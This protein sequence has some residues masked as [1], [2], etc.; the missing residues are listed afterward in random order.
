MPRSYVCSRVHELRGFLE[1]CKWGAPCLAR[2]GGQTQE[3]LPA[4][5]LDV[6]LGRFVRDGRVG[7]GEWEL[8]T[9]ADPTAQASAA[10]VRVGFLY[11]TNVLE[12]SA[13]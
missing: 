9:A 4:S 3:C 7:D 12:V 11:G 1:E 13:L 2:C 8:T 6:G 5:D 10:R